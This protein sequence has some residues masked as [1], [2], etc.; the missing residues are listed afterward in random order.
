MKSSTL[1][2]HGM[3]CGGCVNSVT[4]ALKNVEGVEEAKVSLESKQAEVTFDETKTDLQKI[5]EAVS[6]AGYEVVA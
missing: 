4:R 5:G 3:T 1:K 2:I 6:E